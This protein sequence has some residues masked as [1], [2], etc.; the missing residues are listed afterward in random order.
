MENSKKI[1]QFFKEINNETMHNMQKIEAS[2][3]II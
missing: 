2:R 3:G 1:M